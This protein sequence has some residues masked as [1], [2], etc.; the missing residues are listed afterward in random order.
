MLRIPLGRLPLSSRDRHAA[1]RNYFCDKDADA[2]ETSEGWELQ[3]HWPDGDDRHVDPLLDE[4]LLWWGRDITRS[5]MAFARHR[6]GRVLTSLYDTWTLHSWSE[7]LELRGIELSERLIVLHVDDHLDLAAPRLI[8][9]PGVFRDAIT[10]QRVDLDRS[11]SVRNAIYS[12]AIGMGSFLTPFVHFARDLEIRH[13]RQPPK[14]LDTQSYRMVC[15]TEPDT[16]LSPGAPRPA[17]HLTPY[18]GELPRRN[19]YTVTCDL[20]TWLQ[21]IGECAMLLHIDMDYFNNRYD[22]D[23]D[24]SQRADM[25]DPSIEQVLAKIDDV[26]EALRTFDHTKIK[27]VVISYSPGFF[28]AEYWRC[29][30]MRL[31]A[32]LES[33]L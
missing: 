15:V 6:R 12:G 25:H 31:G 13:L 10:G 23:S 16:L 9:E 4:G 32:G 19:L 8:A 3:L 11:D 17:V 22:G 24:W 14:T 20:K 30:D 26:L 29:A 5:T 28:P 18:S 21:D 27:D 7:Q 1:L 33:L 2:R